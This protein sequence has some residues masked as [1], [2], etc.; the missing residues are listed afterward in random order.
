MAFNYA[1]LPRLSTQQ[2]KRFY[3]KVIIDSASGCWIWQ[4]SQ[5]KCGY[6]NVRINQRTLLP[7]RIA[8]FIAY[9]FDPSGFLVCHT[10]D[11]RLCVNPLHLFLGNHSD[12]AQDCIKKGRFMS[13]QGSEN[14]QAKL[15]EAEVTEI[16]RLA[17][18]GFTQSAIAVR[19]GLRQ[20]YVSKIINRKMWKHI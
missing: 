2:I 7:H 3:S 15:T 13:M 12:N 19:Y 10:C 11:N 17:N 5:H 20:G 4:G 18:E 8:Y 14:P 9:H 16:R 6:G 1:T